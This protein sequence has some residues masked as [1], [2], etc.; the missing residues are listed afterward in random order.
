MHNG[1]LKRSAIVHHWLAVVASHI[2]WKTRS[3]FRLHLLLY[4]FQDR[5]YN[6][7]DALYPLT[8]GKFSFIVALYGVPVKNGGVSWTSRTRIIRMV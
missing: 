4:F 2:D 5:R 7:T 8:I 6:V 3:G 1:V